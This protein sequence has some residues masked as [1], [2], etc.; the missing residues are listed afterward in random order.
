MPNKKRIKSEIFIDEHIFG[1]EIYSITIDVTNISDKDIG[2]LY[3]EPILKCGREVKGVIDNCDTQE[4][5]L[6]QLENKKIRLVTEMEKLVLESYEKKRR[7]SLGWW[8]LKKEFLFNLIFSERNLLFRLNNLEK[9]RIFTS[10]HDLNE[11]FT[12]DDWKDVERLE[13]DIINDGDEYIKNAFSINKNKLESILEKINKKNL[14]K[15]NLEK[16]IPLLT[17]QTVTFPFKF[18]APVTLTNIDKEIQFKISYKDIEKDEMIYSSVKTKTQVFASK[19]SVPLGSCIGSII[20]YFIKLIL[21]SS[22][23]Q[24]IFEWK[25]LIG[26]ILLGIVIGITTYKKYNTAIKIAVEDFTGGLIIGALAGIFSKEFIEK[27]KL[28]VG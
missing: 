11:A 6:S 22:D 1:G 13:K 18:K 4:F 25:T 9:I 14:D 3:V 19:F 21:L 24:F 28:F 17:D 23:S 16:G 12:I 10:S 26:T 15:K 2:N 27:L 5:E 7:K 20:G 8:T